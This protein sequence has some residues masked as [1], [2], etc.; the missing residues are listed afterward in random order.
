MSDIS[1]NSA[2][3][4]LETNRTGRREFPP[5]TRSLLRVRVPVVV[6]LAEK[7]H[8]LG[9]I[10]ELVPGQILQFEKSCEDP[11]EL[12]ISNCKIAAGEAVKVGDKFGLRITAIIP[13]DERFSPVKPVQKSG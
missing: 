8:K 7:K 3:N 10:L 9:H 6:A 11:L 2:S 5:Y 4:G 1:H 12:Q 13:P